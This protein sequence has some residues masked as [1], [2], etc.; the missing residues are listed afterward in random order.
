MKKSRAPAVTQD[1]NRKEAILT[2]A[3]TLFSQKGYDGTPVPEIAEAAEVGVGTIYR[4]FGD[5]ADVVNSLYSSWKLRMQK[6]MLQGLEPT[7]DHQTGFKLLCRHVLEFARE[8]PVAFTFLETHNHQPYLNR[9]SLKI[10]TTFMDFIQSFVRE[11]QRKKRIRSVDPDLLIA[12]VYGALVGVFKLTG[13]QL[14]N[15][16]IESAADSCWEM[17]RKS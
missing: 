16:Q 13:G 12:L 9:S 4:Y 2:A 1:A 5:K 15:A 8:H 6:Q 3:L 10:E 7:L 14:S 11:G 17:A